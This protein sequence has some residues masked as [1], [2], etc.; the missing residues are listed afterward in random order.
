MCECSRP[1]FPRAGL[2]LRD[3]LFLLVVQPCRHSVFA[4][5]M[6]EC[7]SAR[8]TDGPALLTPEP[9]STASFPALQLAGGST[10]AAQLQGLR[11]KDRFNLSQNT[12]SDQRLL[13]DLWRIK[14]RK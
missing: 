5:W 10:L 13:G 8:A 9:L 4:E 6:T 12:C 3:S 1:E 14:S 2:V 7:M 11:T